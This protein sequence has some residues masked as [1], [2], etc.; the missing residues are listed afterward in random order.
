MDNDR[1]NQEAPLVPK[2]V[3]FWLVIVIAAGILF[4]GGRF[5]AAPAGG[6]EALAYLSHG[7]MPMLISLPRG[8]G[9]SYPGCF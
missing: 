8:S 4:I 5:L 3:L 9:M 2:M 1:R 7:R 6:A